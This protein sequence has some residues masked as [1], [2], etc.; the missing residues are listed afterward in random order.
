MPLKVFCCCTYRTSGR[1]WTQHDWA[2]CFFV[3]ALKNKPLKG[4]ARI[5][6]PLGRS[7]VLDKTTAMNAPSWFGEIVAKR[8]R[9]E[10]VGTVAL[11]PIPNSAC[12]ITSELPPRTLNLAKAL[13]TRLPEQATVSDVLRWSDA[14]PSA[15]QAG[16]TRDPHI[17]CTRLRLIGDAPIDRRTV[18]IDDVLASGGH[19]QA[20]AA[21]LTKHGCTVAGAIC[22][23]RA[24]NEFVG[25]DAFAMRIESVPDF[26]P[27]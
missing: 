18:L 11:V 12:C 26:I 27:M 13:E 7:V 5:P 6:L 23:G 10:S 22:A 8:I 1:D 14:Y 16:G 9:W 17:L 21:L 20:A 15:H 2:A 3:K 19:L 25:E 24:D 4:Y